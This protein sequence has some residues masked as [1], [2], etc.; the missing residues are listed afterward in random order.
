MG[1]HNGAKAS[2]LPRRAES[3]EVTS[4]IQRLDVCWLVVAGQRQGPMPFDR[5]LER[6]HALH[7][8]GVDLCQLTIISAQHAPTKPPDTNAAGHG[9]A[10]GCEM[11]VV[12]ARHPVGSGQPSAGIL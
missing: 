6:L 8:K 9:A 10:G 4:R 5:A 1:Q 12:G 7:S 2:P 11:E 3:K